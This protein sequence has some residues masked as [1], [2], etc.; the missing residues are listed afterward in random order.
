[1]N[2]PPRW[3][4]D[5]GLL[6]G[7]VMCRL[8][9]ACLSIFLLFSSPGWT[10]KN[11]QVHLQARGD[12]NLPPYEFLDAT[13]T[14]SGFNID[15]LRAVAD[16]VGLNVDIRL[17]PWSKVRD[18]LENGRIDIATGMIASAEREGR[19]DF[20][21]PF[22]TINYAAFAREDS[23][24]QSIEDLRGLEL[25]VQRGDIMH[26]YAIANN[27]TSMLILVESQVEALRMLA[28]GKHDAALTSKLQGLYLIHK[29]KLSNVEIAES[30]SHPQDLCFAVAEDNDEL[31]AKLNKG[32]RILKSSNRYEDIYQ[33]WFG[34]YD[35][36]TFVE[37]LLDYILLGLIPLLA[38]LLAA[39]GWSWALK[40]QV[41]KKTQE[42]QQEM[43]NRQRVESQLKN[44]KQFQRFVEAAPVPMAVVDQ[45]QKILYLNDKFTELFGYTHEELPDA[46]SWWL[47]AHPDESYRKQVRDEFYTHVYPLIRE[48]EDATVEMRE[49]TCK[50]GSIRSVLVRFSAVGKRDFLVINDITDLKKTESA[51]RQS[52]ARIKGIYHNLAA[53]IEVLDN[54]G[55]VVE[56]NNR[57]AAM[58]GYTP[59]ELIGK[60]PLEFTHP[61]DL[62]T[63]QEFLKKALQVQ[64]GTYRREKRYLRKDGSFFWGDLSFT[65]IVGASGEVIEAIGIIFDITER[66]AIEQ[67]LREVNRD[68]EAFV[69]SVSH[70]LRTPLTPILG[71]AEYLISNYQDKLDENA[72]DCLEEIE[73]AGNRMLVL[74]EDLLLLASVGHLERP[75]QPVDVE[76]LVQEVVADLGPKIITSGV[77]IH[78][79]TLPTVHAPRT[80][81]R[82]V[83]D[84]LIGNAIRYGGVEGGAIDVGG[85]QYDDRT[86]YYVRD[87]GAGIPDKERKQI[88]NLFCRGSTSKHTK[89][90]GVG[91]ALVLKIARLYGG[92]AWVEETSGGGATI[93]FEMEN[94][95]PS[96]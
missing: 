94:L 14:P 51:L 3:I 5:R 9:L 74:I 54:N 61:E 65:Q 36:R 66:K 67:Q 20:S 92:E 78:L 55:V 83:F 13:G 63:S 59:K 4:L 17:E 87:H 56:V 91:L 86:R 68:L 71:Y 29:F 12:H 27:L 62:D 21:T 47:L 50:D 60:N 11:G 77:T 73:K 58:L 76:A 10:E 28:S 8:V 23:S 22:L 93:F 18:D 30:F 7:E 6:K 46:E 39:F 32:L 25:I 43:S 2:N 80:L 64:V 44:E 40:R 35:E 72:L 88:F 42:L 24:V 38:L 1:L 69:Y 31:Q 45:Q 84:N 26:D 15:V 89:G 57:L 52:E 75:E 16:V 49:V 48:G 85:V 37:E 19:V 95:D 82:Q 53:G 79:Q 34:I 41:A 96:S 33:R 90:T 70:D 81:L